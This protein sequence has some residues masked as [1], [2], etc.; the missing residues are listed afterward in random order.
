[1]RNSIIAANTALGGNSDYNGTL[2]SQGYNLIGSNFETTIIGDATGN[3]VGTN[4]NPVN[5]QLAALAAN[6]GATRTRALLANSPAI[7]SGNA[8]NS[9]AADQRGF[10]RNGTPDKGAFEANGAVPP[11]PVVSAVSRKTHPGAGTLDINLPLTG[12]PGV[13]CRTAGANGTHTLVIN[14]ANNLTS[15]GSATV[16][17][18]TGS[19]SS[20][21]IGTDSRQYVVNLTGVTNAQRLTVTLNN[22]TDSF[23][24]TSSATPVTIALL[25]GDTNG[26]G[27]VNAT[28]IG[29]TKAGSGQVVD[30]V[31]FRQDVN[32]SGSIN[33][34]D[35]GLVKAQSGTVLP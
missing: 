18:G 19:V 7:N 1:V 12:T 29:Q 24:Y 15:V 23:G 27:G 2:T 32:V 21:Q 6:G 9:P 14:F 31:N 33:A 26:S 5:A 13:E 17:S 16:T 28:D 10:G 20:S 22:V 30:A 34:S 8:A 11:V 3:L 35:I 4:A 25:Q